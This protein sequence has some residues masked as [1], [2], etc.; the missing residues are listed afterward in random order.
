MKLVNAADERSHLVRG[1]STTRR[2][3]P[4]SFAQSLSE[5]DRKDRP[6]P[7][8]RRS[9]PH[10]FSPLPANV[11]LLGLRGRATSVLTL[12]NARSADLPISLCL[13]DFA[14][15]TTRS[16]LHHTKTFSLT[17]VNSGVDLALEAL[18]ASPRDVVR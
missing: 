5:D 9:P 8:A 12:V 11:A 4:P 16:P 18:D 6:A 2:F 1:F 15:I 13:L 7:R 3:A 17:L 14:P 10:A